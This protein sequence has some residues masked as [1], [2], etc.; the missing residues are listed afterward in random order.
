MRIRAIPAWSSPGSGDS[1]S[2][3]EKRL[4]ATTAYKTRWKR[5]EEAPSIP[6]D[7]TTAQDSARRGH[8]LDGRARHQSLAARL[9]AIQDHLIEP[10]HIGGARHKAARFLLGSVSVREYRLYRISVLPLECTYDVQSRLYLFMAG[11]II[12]K[13]IPVA[14]QV[15]RRILYLEESALQGCHDGLQLSVQRGGLA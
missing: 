12:V 1:G 6:G 14:I 13:R 9:T 4:A 10:P 11:S 2:V 7:R 3:H 15:S 5:I 8:P